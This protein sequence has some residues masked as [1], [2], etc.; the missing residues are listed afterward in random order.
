MKHNGKKLKSSVDPKKAYILNLDIDMNIVD[1][2]GNEKEYTYL[3]LQDFTST[4]DID[5]I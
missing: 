2:E 5:R 4:K 1:P 3:M